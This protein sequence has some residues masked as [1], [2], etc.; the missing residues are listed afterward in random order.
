MYDFAGNLT[1]WIAK[2]NGASD[3]VADFDKN[4]TE[5]VL[6]GLMQGPEAEVQSSA[7]AIA[8]SAWQLAVSD[9]NNFNNALSLAGSV[10]ESADARAKQL[11]AKGDRARAEFYFKIAGNQRKDIGN[12]RRKNLAIATLIEVP[13]IVFNFIKGAT[14]LFSGVSIYLR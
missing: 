10:A 7:I 9:I 8:S 12:I 14:K 2:K 11:L 3:V 5:F 4:L 13:G 1:A 6:T